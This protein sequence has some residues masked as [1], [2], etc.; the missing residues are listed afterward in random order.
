[1]GRHVNS[2]GAGGEKHVLAVG[3]F[4]KKKALGWASFRV[5]TRPA[6]WRDQSQLTSPRTAAVFSHV[7]WRRQP[8]LSARHHQEE[9]L[10]APGHK[11]KKKVKCSRYR[12]RHR[13]AGRIYILYV[14]TL[15]GI[16]VRYI[17]IYLINSPTQDFQKIY[18][19]FQSIHCWT[20]P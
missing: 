15:D 9:T 5:L 17:C 7:P 4:S 16:T 18:L 10:T 12:R 8:D 1:M 19:E 2:A 20:S 6:R 14:Y 11:A 13:A 3:L